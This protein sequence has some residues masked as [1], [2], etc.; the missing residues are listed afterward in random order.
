MESVGW[1]VVLACVSCHH[2]DTQDNGT[3]RVGWGESD[4]VPLIGLAE[5]SW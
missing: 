4:R 5:P 3:T 1:D 2:A